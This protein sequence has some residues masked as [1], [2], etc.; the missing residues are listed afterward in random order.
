MFDDFNRDE[1]SGMSDSSQTVGDN[2]TWINQKC[3]VLD[4]TIGLGAPELESFLRSAFACS[5]S[6]FV[7]E[8]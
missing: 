8:E 4:D 3:R 5:T 6:T 1:I 2:G 7:L